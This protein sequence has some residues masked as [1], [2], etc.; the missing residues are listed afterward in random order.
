[1]EIKAVL[2]DWDLTMARVLGDISTEARLQALFEWAGMVYSVDE[3]ETAVSTARQAMHLNGYVPQTQRDIAKYY[4][5]VLRNLGE[6]DVSWA[7]ANYLYDA[8]SYMPSVLYDD[9]LP[10]LRY[11]DQAGIKSGIISNHSRLI[12]PVIKEAIGDLIYSEHIL[13]SQE[14]GIYKPTPSIFL[15][16]AE[17]LK[18]PPEACLFIGDNLE[19]DAIGA[20]EK[21]EFQTGLWLDRGGVG[22]TAVSPLPQISR[23]L[24]SRIII[25]FARQANNRSEAS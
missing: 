19:G 5:H 20:V 18:L 25:S 9:T 12:R 2:F 13:I 16:A 22:E 3:V 7:I 8:Y 10:V 23:N 11:L 21:G 1:M 14:V 17:A 15:Q 6:N 4:Q 24:F